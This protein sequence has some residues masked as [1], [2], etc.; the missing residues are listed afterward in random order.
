[1]DVSFRG[2]NASQPRTVQARARQ[3]SGGGQAN[4]GH[5]WRRSTWHGPHLTISQGYA[6]WAGSAAIQGQS[7]TP[8]TGGRRGS[9]VECW[10]PL[11]AAARQ[12]TNP[13]ESGRLATSRPDHRNALEGP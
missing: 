11:P 4:F 1:M 10:F 12:P 5:A 3:A 6:A 13:P 9:S 2:G 8:S 7:V